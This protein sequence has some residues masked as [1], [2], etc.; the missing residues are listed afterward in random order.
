M[1]LIASKN[2]FR[3]DH[4]EMPISTRLTDL[5]RYLRRRRPSL[6][7]Q[8]AAQLDVSPVALMTVPPHVLRRMEKQV[9]FDELTRVLRRAP[10]MA[11]V[12]REI[13]RTERLT[14]VR[15]VCA[16]ID[17]DGLKRVNDTRGHAAG[18]RLLREVA[19]AL[20]DR[21]R[22][23]DLVFRYG[24]DEFVCLLPGSGLESAERILAKLQAEMAATY[25]ESF[26]VGFAE[27]KPGDDARKL[28][29]RADAALYA[30]RAI[31]RNR[32]PSRRPEPR[33]RRA[34]LDVA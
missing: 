26:S 7:A 5:A 4:S 34:R 21:L 16:F 1:R 13:A 12:E 24:G 10:G 8:L 27:L 22:R 14:D 30:R 9:A 25:G 18:D 2:N 11:A 23:G 3:G 15:L 28:V 29:E 20:S 32:V 19:A 31:V 6:R 17:V 33:E